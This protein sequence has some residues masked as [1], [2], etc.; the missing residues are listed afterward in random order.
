[1]VLHAPYAVNFSGQ[2]FIMQDPCGDALIS[3]QSTTPANDAQPVA[4]TVTINGVNRPVSPSAEWSLPI[5]NGSIS[6]IPYKKV[7]VLQLE[8]AINHVV[9][10]PSA[11]SWPPYPALVFTAIVIPGTDAPTSYQYPIPNV[12]NNDFNYVGSVATMAGDTGYVGNTYRELIAPS[13]GYNFPVPPN[14]AVAKYISYYVSGSTLHYTDMYGQTIT[15]I[16]QPG[17]V[18]V[19]SKGFADTLI[20]QLDLPTYYDIAQGFWDS[21]SGAAAGPPETGAFTWDN[22]GYIKGNTVGSFTVFPLT[23]KGFVALTVQVVPQQTPI[24]TELTYHGYA[25]GIID[26]SA[27][28]GFSSTTNI[29]GQAPA[30]SI[31]NGKITIPT[32]SV[33]FSANNYVFNVNVLPG[34]PATLPAIGVAEGSVYNLSQLV[35][36]DPNIAT[37]A[38][39]WS[40][41][42]GNGVLGTPVAG[43]ATWSTASTIGA[44]YVYGVMVAIIVP[45]QM[46]TSV[47][48]IFAPQGRSVNLF[49]FFQA[50]APS[51]VLLDIYNPAGDQITSTQNGD[52]RFGNVN[53]TKLSCKVLLSG[54]EV[55][56]FGITAIDVIVISD[57]A[58][59]AYTAPGVPYPLYLPTGETLMLMANTGEQ[60]LLAPLPALPMTTRELSISVMSSLPSGAPPN[61]T[62]YN[63]IVRK[64]CLLL[65]GK[66]GGVPKE[67]NLIPFQLLSDTITPITL[68]KNSAKK[69]TIEMPEGPTYQIAYVSG[70][71]LPSTIVD[72]KTQFITFDYTTVTVVSSFGGGTFNF[73]PPT[74]KTLYMIAENY[75]GRNTGPVFYTI[76]LVE[77]ER[78]VFDVVNSRTIPG[79][80]LLNPPSPL[81]PYLAQVAGGVVVSRVAGQDMSQTFVV[82]VGGKYVQYLINIVPPVKLSQSLFYVSGQVYTDVLPM[83][84]YDYTNNIPSINLSSPITLSTIDFNYAEFTN[85]V[86]KMVK[87][88]GKVA[89]RQIY[90]STVV[91]GV[92][93]HSIDPSG[94]SGALLSLPYSSNGVTFTQY[95]APTPPGGPQ[96]QITQIEVVLDKP[97]LNV[98]QYYFVDTL[99]NSYLYDFQ[100]V[101]A[102]THSDVYL[103]NG[104]TWHADTDIIY[105]GSIT[106]VGHDF[107]LPTNSGNPI[108]EV[109]V[110]L[111]Y[112]ITSPYHGCGITFNIMDVAGKV[113]QYAFCQNADFTFRDPIDSYMTTLPTKNLYGGSAAFKTLYFDVKIATGAG[114]VSKMSVSTLNAALLT[115]SVMEN[116]YVVTYTMVTP[117]G[118]GVARKVFSTAV[119]ELT[120]VPLPYPAVSDLTLFTN[121]S[122]LLPAAPA[123]PAS[124]VANGISWA[125]Q[126]VTPGPAGSILPP[127]LTVGSNT[128]TY[129]VKFMYPAPSSNPNG[130][131]SAVVVEPPMPGVFTTVCNLKTIPQPAGVDLNRVIKINDVVA[132]DV[133]VNLYGNNADY[134]ITGVKIGSQSGATLV[135]GP[136]KIPDMS[137]GSYIG[138]DLTVYVGNCGSATPTIGAGPQQLTFQPMKATFPSMPNGIPVVINVIYSPNGGPSTTLSITIHVFVWD[139]LTMRHE[140]A[141]ATPLPGK[142][143]SI[144]PNGTA[145]RFSMT[146]IGGTFISF[147]H[148]GTTLSGTSD[149]LIDW[150]LYVSKGIYIFS[151][152]PTVRNYFLF[153]TAEVVLFTVAILPTNTPAKIINFPTTSPATIDLPATDLLEIFYPTLETPLL[154]ANASMG[155]LTAASGA[156]AGTGSLTAYVAKYFG[157]GQ[158]NV[159]IQIVIPTYGSIAGASAGSTI[160]LTTLI[161]TCAYV[162]APTLITPTPQFILPVNQS[163][164][165]TSEM[166]S[167]NSQ[168]STSTFIATH[169]STLP[170]SWTGSSPPVGSVHNLSDGIVISCPIPGTYTLQCTLTNGGTS[171]LDVLITFIAY[172]PSNVEVHDVSGWTPSYTQTFLSN[173]VSYSI[174]GVSYGLNTSKYVPTIPVGNAIRV[175]LTAANP[176]IVVSIQLAPDANGDP[177][178]GLLSYTYNIVSESKN[179]IFLVQSTPTAPTASGTQV[180]VA[181]LSDVPTTV[182]ATFGFD[183]MKGPVSPVSQDQ[184]GYRIYSADGSGTIV[185]WLNVSGSKPSFWPNEAGIWNLNGF[186]L[187]IGG[188]NYYINPYVETLA[189]IV[190]QTQPIFAEINTTLNYNLNDFI[191]SGLGQVVFAQWMISFSSAPPTVL[192]SWL[193]ITNGIINTQLLLPSYAGTYTLTANVISV[194]PNGPSQAISFQLVISDPANFEQ[195]PVVVV[196]NL[197]TTIELPAKILSIDGTALNSTTYI[198]N[199]I[200]LTTAPTIPASA[201]QLVKFKAVATL[202]S[203]IVLKVIT[204]DNKI[205]YVTVTQV[206]NEKNLNIVAFGYNGNLFKTTPSTV[207]SYMASGASVPVSSLAT[208]YYPGTT[209]TIGTAT[210]VINVDGSFQISNAQQLTLTVI[211]TINGVTSVNQTITLSVGLGKHPLKTIDQSP[212]PSISLGTN[213]VRVLVSDTEVKDGESFDLGYATFQVSGNQLNISNITAAF[214]PTL[215]QAENDIASKVNIVSMMIDINRDV[216]T[217]PIYTVPLNSTIQYVLPFE[218]SRLTY[219]TMTVNGSDLKIKL[220]TDVGVQFANVSLSGMALTVE[221]LGVLA[222]SR[223]I[224]FM[225]KNGTYTYIIVQTINPSS[226]TSRV[227]AVGSVIRPP[228][229]LVYVTVGMLDGTQIALPGQT[230]G[231]VVEITV[232]GTAGTNYLQ[233]LA[234]LLTASFRFYA[235][236]SDGSVQFYVVKFVMQNVFV[237]DLTKIPVRAFLGATVASTVNPVVFGQV[238]VVVLGNFV[239]NPASLRV[240]TLVSPFYGHFTVSLFPVV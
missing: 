235:T 67:L 207:V 228:T 175:M 237:S 154:N 29:S 221:A 198:T 139:P 128:I 204:S 172:N 42:T 181:T 14:V 107:T 70:S 4:V 189:A 22:K 188:T 240:L 123:L 225:D 183:P 121:S 153:T 217:Q 75:F 229:G 177:V 47:A 145:S 166:V 135:R 81:P 161:Y 174:S 18:T 206:A 71:G 239:M 215:V 167:I 28:A 53:V 203:P 195:I 13:S 231:G 137:N 185:G 122:L 178:V 118:S 151:T 94:A 46:N 127:L 95:Q 89:S 160:T 126:F 194:K 58:D 72:T 40:E 142:T 66:V 49:N 64:E 119:L 155:T 88:S 236:L 36:L 210:V 230:L 65:H 146:N 134:V 85:G 110:S 205:N 212:A 140:V 186:Y 12:A 8:T 147:N 131:S 159:P 104:T 74:T 30:L 2:D 170:A 169:A 190:T 150:S 10:T 124:V 3:Y 98:G 69:I 141:K 57:S 87:I 103:F 180:D 59:A 149:D 125:V 43:Q 62:G 184:N 156:T 15:G 232:V 162:A 97:G 233:V 132:D 32:A 16:G 101:P 7:L 197:D 148:D 108:P 86:F 27:L 91:A 99:G 19:G 173:I 38:F 227:V 11:S 48:T 93:M 61:T 176:T 102:P 136:T 96:P 45:K 138:S 219:N 143:R 164:T 73:T 6:Y 80:T 35:N 68:V 60:I 202:S 179:Q 1:V 82:V 113:E 209:T 106:L 56:Y 213:V 114:G 77:G 79:A 63:V 26:V 84:L 191:V 115:S 109:N 5:Y 193:G 218:P 130:S 76:N 51:D 211:Y 116:I 17:V 34:P 44:V 31:M 90:L 224:G 111:Y 33:K 54:V 220:Y 52:L 78:V 39:T 201:G 238:G 223:P 117:P 226:T 20:V 50:T 9:V 144:G 187:T 200:K 163:F 105:E 196:N 100:N 37:N 23:T 222:F 208:T 199:N 192:P 92:S 234:G 120:A 152:T 214:E 55:I 83:G 25:N 129:N 41:D 158:V 24:P 171:T 216:T 157:T 133:L 21:T 112:D 165:L 168:L 182:G